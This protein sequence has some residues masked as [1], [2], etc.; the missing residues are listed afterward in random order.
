[1]KPAVGWLALLLL[2]ELT[3]VS[4][5]IWNARARPD[6]PLPDLAK[7]D[8]LA[9]R[10]IQ[11]LQQ[12]VRTGKQRSGD[13]RMLAEAYLGTGYYVEA[14][15]CFKMAGQL[16]PTDLQALYG[17]AFCLE[18]IGQTEDA[19]VTLKHIIRL[20]N[21]EL[22]ETCWYQVGRCYL[23][24]ENIAEA[25]RA[26]REIPNSISATYQLA[27]L[28]IRSN[29]ASEAIP[30]LESALQQYPNSLK[31]IQLR[32]RAAQDMGDD[33]LA[34]DLHDREKRAEYV[35]VLEYSQS[36]VS[37]FAVRY[38]IAAVLSQAM[39]LKSSGSLQQRKQVLGEALEIIRRHRLWNYRS[40]F[41]AAAYVEMGLGNFE[42]ARR[43]I[44]EVRTHAQDGVDL[45]E[46]EGLLL[47]NEGKLTEANRVWERGLQM[48]PSADLHQLVADANTDSPEIA[49]HHLNRRL[50]LDSVGA[51]RTNRLD[52]AVTGLQKYV[53]LITD[54]SFAWFYLG[55]AHKARGEFDKALFAYAQCVR[56][57]P[58]YFRA[59]EAKRN[60]LAWMETNQ[61]TGE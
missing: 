56:L 59:V 21:A 51:F 35:L 22:R 47:E 25:E 1:M 14:E 58:G 48:L 55:E 6:I 37:A 61:Q 57:S 27:K 41:L 60:L 12:R 52:A 46:L 13:W 36:F 15:R 50:L 24:Q 28:L 38:G 32:M 53:G 3:F 9:A 54:D 31:L 30:L 23:R 10:Q 17:Q 33:L 45:L 7:L 5:S 49:K 18:R 29:R 16:Q 4:V 39:E 8:Q 43:L 20:A 2:I 19:I 11:E 42:D 40:V 26:F 44:I 34:K